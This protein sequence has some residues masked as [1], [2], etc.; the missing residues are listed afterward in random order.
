MRVL[1]CELRKKKVGEG[2]NSK[3]RI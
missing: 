3:S 1:I 2:Q